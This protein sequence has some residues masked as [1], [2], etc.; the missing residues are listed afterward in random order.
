MTLLDAIR[1]RFDRLRG[2]ASLEVKSALSAPEPWLLEAFGAVPSAS[3][4]T[5]TPRSAMTVPAVSAAVRAIAETTAALPLHLYR[6]LEDGG[7]AREIEHPAHRLLHG[8]VSDWQ[9]AA[10]FREQITT[11]ALQHG[12][13]F[14]FIVRV[15]D[16]RPYA[17]QRLQPE[18]VTVALDGIG[19][20]VYLVSITEQGRQLQR[21]Y[22]YRDILHIRAP[23]GFDGVSGVSPIKLARE[24]IGLAILLEQHGSKL[25][26]NGGRPSGVLKFPNQLGEEPAQRIRSSWQ[27]AFGGGSYKVAVLEEGGDY[28]AIAFNSVDSQYHELRQFTVLEIARAFRVPPSMLQDY[29]RATWSN[30][31]AMRADFIDFALRR[32]LSAWEDEVRLKLLSPEERGDLF[33]EFELGAFLRADTETRFGA[34]SVA[35]AAGFMSPNEVRAL[36][37][38]APRDGGDDFGNPFTTSNTGDPA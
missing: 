12:G 10:S 26:A 29:G 1:T 25:F 13:G 34:Y 28:Q 37:N 36:E 20:P 8:E 31:E 4:I 19:D 14:A 24:A 18:A 33:A 35:I 11:D 3:G 38:R 2:T 6:R 22:S 17:L 9:S 15:D 23:A 27:G 16:G 30:S 7:K 5:V 32:W 21:R